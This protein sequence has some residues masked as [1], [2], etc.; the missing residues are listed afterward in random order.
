MDIE[1]LIGKIFKDFDSSEVSDILLLENDVYVLYNQE[2]TKFPTEGY[3][4]IDI[5]RDIFELSS[6]Y[7]K[8]GLT[9]FDENE[10]KSK[11]VNFSSINATFS[12]KTKGL[13]FRI[14][15]FLS[16]GKFVCVLRLI[17]FSNK[18]F[19]DLGFNM[20]YINPIIEKKHGLILISG[21]A[22]AGKSTTAATLIEHYSKAFKWHIVTIEDPIE[23]IFTNSS[24]VI[25]QREIGLDTPNYT[26]ALTDVLRERPSAIFVGE[27]VAKDVAELALQ[28]AT[29]GQLVISTIHASSAI[30]TVERFV[31]LYEMDFV[32]NIRLKLA[33]SLL[34]IISQRLVRVKVGDTV[35]LRL[36]Y[37]VL[38]N[39]NQSKALISSPNQRLTLLYDVLKRQGV[40]LI[41]E[42]L[43]RLIDKNMIC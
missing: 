8:Y 40:K 35:K 43:D 4:F 41:I 21:P 34:A 36:L 10:L 30:E 42:Q 22:G 25:S 6:I 39:D 24:S 28:A 26:K 3:N 15:I 29:A 38:L 13:R 17:Y 5:L 37:E 14:H 12:L 33:Y 23:Y 2:L 18:K 16:M 11:I 9:A 32:S 7:K 31:N 19:T 27:I 20:K 1:R